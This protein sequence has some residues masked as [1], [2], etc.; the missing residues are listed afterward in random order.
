MAALV[1]TQV[2]QAKVDQ[3]KVDQ[4][5]C[6]QLTQQLQQQMLQ[7]VQNVSLHMTCFTSSLI[8]MDLVL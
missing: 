3:A 2:Q 8:S 1:L 7:D 5:V 6:Q 4:I